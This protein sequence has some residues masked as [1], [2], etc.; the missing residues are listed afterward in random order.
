MRDKV[1]ADLGVFD[2]DGV[3]HEGGQSYS[4]GTEAF[5]CRIFLES[6]RG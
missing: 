4:T 2:F 5:A 3:F 6:G 1:V